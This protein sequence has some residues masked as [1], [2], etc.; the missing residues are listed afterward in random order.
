VA[1]SERPNP[2]RRTWGRRCEIGCESWPDSLDYSVCPRCGGE[3]ERMSN[4]RPLSDLEARRIK[5]HIDFEEF[6]ENRCRKL[7]IPVSGKL[8]SSYER[9]LPPLDARLVQPSTSPKKSIR[10]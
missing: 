6:Y 3:T 5:T 10:A 9:Q 8:P 1:E 2:D 7:K 4:L